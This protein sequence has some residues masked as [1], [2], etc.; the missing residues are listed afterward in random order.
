MNTRLVK[1][2]SIF[3]LSILFLALIIQSIYSVS[4][5]LDPDE[6]HIQ[7]M[8]IKEIRPYYDKNRL[9][10]EIILE[11]SYTCTELVEVLNIRSFVVKN[12]LYEPVCVI[13]K[14]RATI[15]Y[16]NVEKV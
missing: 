16:I 11:K 4:G 15:T 2:A 12:K 9:Q 3:F 14:D 7:S 13:K 5:H 6:V 10:L 1:Y 8:G